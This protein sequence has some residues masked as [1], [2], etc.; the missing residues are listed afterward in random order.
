MARKELRKWGNKL[1][2]HK[3]L[4]QSGILPDHDL[5]LEL[6]DLEGVTR[7]APDFHSPLSSRNWRSLAASEQV[8]ESKARSSPFSKK[9]L[10]VST[11]T[12]EKD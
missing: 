7:A 11:L 5:G 8:L 9:R 1:F 6:V 10:A 3:E 4:R 2:S 12:K